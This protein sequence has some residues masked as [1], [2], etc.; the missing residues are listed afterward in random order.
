MTELRCCEALGPGA[1]C[2]RAGCGKHTHFSV[3]WLLP[4][5]AADTRP[6]CSVPCA[7]SLSQPGAAVG[8]SP[9]VPPHKT[10]HGE[11]GAR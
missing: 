11:G 5:R 10:A 2:A 4:S 3:A 8:P 9:A 7:I 1:A 6:A